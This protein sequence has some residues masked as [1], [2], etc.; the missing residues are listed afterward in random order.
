VWD[1]HNLFDGTLKRDVVSS[2]AHKVRLSLL[3][4]DYVI[5]ARVDSVIYYVVL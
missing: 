2:T 1:T 3:R 4:V 5:D